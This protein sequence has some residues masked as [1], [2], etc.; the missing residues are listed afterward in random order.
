MAARETSRLL[1]RPP[2]PEDLDAFVEIHSDPEVARHLIL[3]GSPG[4]AGAWQMLALLAGHW[5]LRGYGQWTVIE[6][7]TGLVIGRVGLWNPE[8]WPDLEIGWVIRRSHWNR[9]YATEAAREAVA[10]AFDTIGV[11]HV[12]SLI[13]PDNARS[14]R[15]AE[16]LGE[17]VEGMHPMNGMHMRLYGLR[18]WR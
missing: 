2:E 10:F 4:R 11:N 3:R 5:Q 14:I 18:R 8:G 12:I 1:L 16:K 6:R 15:V 13:H 9:G 7:A 17:Q